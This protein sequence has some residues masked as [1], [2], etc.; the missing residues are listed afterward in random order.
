M[1]LD[2]VMWWGDATAGSVKHGLWFL[3]KRLKSP[4]P[5]DSQR[6]FVL[7]LRLTRNRQETVKWFEIR[8]MSSKNQWILCVNQCEYL[9]MNLINVALVFSGHSLVE[10]L[11]SPP[12][13][14][15][16]SVLTAGPEV[17]WSVS[18]GFCLPGPLIYASLPLISHA[19]SPLRPLL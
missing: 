16:I 3:F 6:L 10:V 2:R 7:K 18:P 15:V 9:E 8:G 1:T 12:P 4:K 17:V 13:P 11:T 5:Q 14:P 19:R